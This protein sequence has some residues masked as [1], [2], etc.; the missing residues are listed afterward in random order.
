MGRPE[1]DELLL[2]VRDHARAV[3]RHAAVVV[4]GHEGGQA[5]RLAGIEAQVGADRARASGLN[6]GGRGVRG[7]PRGLVGRVPQLRL[8]QGLVPPVGG[9]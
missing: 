6:T 4:A 5:G 8:A 2:L 1:A 9:A 7:I 3:D